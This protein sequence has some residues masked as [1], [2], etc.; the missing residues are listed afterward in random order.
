M[1]DQGNYWTRQGSR[2]FTR[3]RFIAGSGVMAAGT[4]AMLAGCGD[5][6]AKPAASGTTAAA[7]ATTAAAGATTAAAASPA[8][9]A[10]TKGGTLRLVKSA[11]D[12]GEDPRIYHQTNPEVLFANVFP[13]TYQVT[14]NKVSFDGMV[15]MEQV[16]PL[17]ANF[18]LRPGMKFNNGDPITAEDWAHTMTTLPVLTKDRR[19]HASTP[20]FN[21]IESAKAIDA[22]TWLA[23]P[24]AAQRRYRSSSQR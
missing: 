17:T 15:S 10:A 1:S 2:S 7:G 6:D 14:K 23:F 18:K 8:A 3:R 12:T 4:A 20:L 21:Y 5:D 24:P 16:D 22:T 19:G 9:A 11:A 13:A